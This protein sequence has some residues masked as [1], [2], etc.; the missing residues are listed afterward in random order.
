MH[1]KVPAILKKDDKYAAFKSK[2]LLLDS[3][4]YSMEEFFSDRTLLKCSI[5]GQRPIACN[6]IQY[7]IIS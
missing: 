2:N 5:S 4:R 3:K 7:V 1:N 6:I